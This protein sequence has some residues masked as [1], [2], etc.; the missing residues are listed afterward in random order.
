M[1]ANYIVLDLGM[2][3]S[4]CLSSESFEYDLTKG[5]N[6]SWPAFKVDRILR[7]C[8]CLRRSDIDRL[9]AL[10]INIMMISSVALILHLPLL[11]SLLA[12]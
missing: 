12:C 11:Q 8:L 2:R 10:P 4:L 7:T 9:P 1:C 6:D 3:A 5:K